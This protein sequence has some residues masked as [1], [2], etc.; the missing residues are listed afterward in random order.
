MSK[1]LPKKLG[2]PGPRY[3][4]TIVM[5]LGNGETEL[6][7]MVESGRMPLTVATEIANGTTSRYTTSP[8][9]SIR[10]GR[11]ERRKTESRAS[12]NSKA[13]FSPL[14]RGIAKT[15]PN[16]KSSHQPRRDR[17]EI[18]STLALN[19]PW[20]KERVWYGSD[21]SSSLPPVKQLF[22]DPNFLTLLRAE[23]LSLRWPIS[24]WK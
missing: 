19:V 9:R 23:A 15:S 24:L 20:S 1:K 3:I 21:W 17:K 12:P 2:L 5:L 14:A 8:H 16:P 22:A 13:H 4:A 10:N 7:S 6:I 11:L 18:R